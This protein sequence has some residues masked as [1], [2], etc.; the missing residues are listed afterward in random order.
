M[1]KFTRVMLVV[2]VASIFVGWSLSAMAQQ[3]ANQQ[4]AGGSAV[5]APIGGASGAVIRAEAVLKA[6]IVTYQFDVPVAQHQFYRW[7]GNCYYRNPAGEFAP[8][9]PGYCD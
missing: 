2:S 9:V 6:T 3:P 4:P 7:R 5:G 8:V 1:R